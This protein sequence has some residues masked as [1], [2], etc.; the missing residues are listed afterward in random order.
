MK[1]YQLRVIE[2]EKQLEEKYTRLRKFLETRRDVD[3]SIDDLDLLALQADAMKVYL[4][5]LNLRIQRFQRKPSGI[6]N[7]LQTTTVDSGA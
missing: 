4:N 6:W 1:D 3:V 2:E 5:I 7:S